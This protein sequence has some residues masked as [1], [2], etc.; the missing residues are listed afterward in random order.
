[1]PGRTVTINLWIALTYF[2]FFL[3]FFVTPD[4]FTEPSRLPEPNPPALFSD[5]VLTPKPALKA[6]K[7]APSVEWSFHKTGNN[8]HPSGIEQEMLW[9]M[10]RARLNP[11]HEGLWLA[12]V[13]DPDVTIARNQ[14]NV[15]L[16]VLVSEFAAISAKPP[17]AFD[18]RLYNAAKVHSDD[19]IVQNDQNHTNQFNR[20]NDAGFHWTSVRGNVYSYTFS[21]LH[22]HAG[23]NID[24]GN[25]AVDGMQTG[26]GHRM[27]IMSVDGNYTNVGISAVSETDPATRIGPYVTTGNFCYANENESDH[28]NRFLVGTVWSDENGNELYDAGEGKSNITV[29][30]D[31]GTYYAV[32][33]ASGSYA[34]PVDPGTYTVTFSGTGLPADV[35]RSA[36]VIDRSILLDIGPPYAFTESVETVTA[37]TAVISAIIETNGYPCN[38]HI[39]YGK[40]K[41]TTQTTDPLQTSVSGSISVSLNNLEAST[42]YLYRIIASNS[43]GNDNGEYRSFTTPSSTGGPDDSSDSAD[44]DTGN[45]DATVGGGGGGGCFILS[46]GNDFF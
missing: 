46:A 14:Y 3:T 29:T 33:S 20:I 44:S 27:A 6:V 4:G 19:L 35:Q 21:G 1:M 31:Q 5:P 22:G 45:S 2:S 36:R 38:Y 39:E 10:N 34:I 11:A 7:A 8:Q 9:M 17:A 16:S 43:A 15:D 30:P 12:S 18:V 41:D 28:Y 42:T 40:T 25:N 32:T 23:F 26:R 13:E 37:S 24:W